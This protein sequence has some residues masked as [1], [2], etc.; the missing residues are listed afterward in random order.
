MSHFSGPAARRRS[1]SAARK[2]RSA[3]FSCSGSAA[4]N[5]VCGRIDQRTARVAPA[6][7]VRRNALT[8]LKRVLA[9]LSGVG[10]LLD[11]AMNFLISGW[12]ASTASIFAGSGLPVAG[13]GRRA[14]FSAWNASGVEA[15]KNGK[16]FIAMR[17]SWP[18]SVFSCSAMPRTAALLSG[19]CGSLPG[20]EK[21]P[22]TGVD[23]CENTRAVDSC[24]AAG[25]GAKVPTMQMPLA[26][27]RRTPGCC[28][29]EASAVLTIVWGV[30]FLLP[31]QP[32]IQAK[33]TASAMMI[34]AIGSNNSGEPW[35][36][37][38]GDMEVTL[39]KGSWY[40]Q[41]ENSVANCRMINKL[42]RAA[43]CGAVASTVLLSV[44][45]QRARLNCARILE[46][47]DV[48]SHYI[49]TCANV[50][51]CSSTVARRPLS[52]HV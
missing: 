28:V 45:V 10:A 26:C 50:I 22:R 3:V 15:A 51:T 41:P 4:T 23:G 16:L 5:G 24:A 43:P 2:S 40:I 35:R 25:V 49:F 12:A 17:H 29:P 20:L 27:A 32:P 52:C 44:T 38:G 39:L 33:R 46:V 19:E 8:P 1:R 18:S 13:S 30:T 34:S 11:H 9:R 7:F 36:G 14:A 37:L 21:R 42:M 48:A 31:N 6:A 47:I